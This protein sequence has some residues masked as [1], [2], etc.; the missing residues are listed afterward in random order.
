MHMHSC[1]FLCKC[2]CV[3]VKLYV[4]MNMYNC[5][6]VGL[7]KVI[8]L[9]HR[10]PIRFNAHW[11]RLRSV[12]ASPNTVTVRIEA[13]YF[14]STYVCGLRNS[15]RFDSIPFAYVAT[16]HCIIQFSSE[17]LCPTWYI[18]WSLPTPFIRNKYK[19]KR[20]DTYSVNTLWCALKCFEFWWSNGCYRQPY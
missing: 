8:P 18:M 14:Q 2:L 3:Y 4:H 12:V 6:K 5:Q 15:V 19:K 17:R 11:I 16:G 13:H 10:S 7:S 9:L 20:I 1:I